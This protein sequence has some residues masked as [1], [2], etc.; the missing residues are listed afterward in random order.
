MYKPT[1]SIHQHQV[2]KLDDLPAG[3]RASYQEAEAL[4]SQQLFAFFISKQ[5]FGGILRSLSEPPRVFRITPEELQVITRAGDDDSAHEDRCELA[6]FP[7]QEIL[8]YE[9]GTSL[10]RSWFKLTTVGSAEIAQSV[11]PYS[12]AWEKCFNSLTQCLNEVLHGLKETSS[13]GNTIPY[14]WIEQLGFKFADGVRSEVWSREPIRCLTFQPAQGPSRRFFRRNPRRCLCLT[15]TRLVWF[16]EDVD[17]DVL[18]YGIVRREIPL[19]RIVSM[20]IRSHQEKDQ[21]QGGLLMGLSTQGCDHGV[22]VPIDLGLGLYYTQLI[23]SWKT[24]REKSG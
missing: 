5:D 4:S 6:R 8:F 12:A 10:L 19:S 20:E 18:K 21:R 11:Y 22:E 15:Q 7:I 2:T 24:C 3:F 1:F 23:D 9:T 16:D 14:H 13:R 17:G